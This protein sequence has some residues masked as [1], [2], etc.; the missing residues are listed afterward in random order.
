[1]T[2][3]LSYTKQLESRVAELE[4]ALSK[5]VGQHSSE[6]SSVK[7]ESPASPAEANASPSRR[8]KI[9]DG[10]TDNLDLIK[11]F[12]GL[13]VERDGR[14]SFHGPTSLFQLPSSA[15]ERASPS[16]RRVK[17]LGASRERLINNAWRE[18]AFEQLSAIP[19]PFQYLLDSHWCW[20]QPLFNFVYRPAFTRDMKI[21][22]P[23][24]SDVLLNAILSHS[25]RWCRA[26]PTIGPLLDPFEGGAQFHQRAV[27]GVLDSLSTGYAGIPTVQTLLLLSAQEC[28]QGNRTQ[29]WLYS[30]MAFRL[31]DDL[32][33]SIDSRKY[34]GSAHLTDEDIETRNR[35]FWS[36]YFWDKM[37]SLYF[38]RA[39]IM[40]HSSV[41]PPRRIL[42]DTSEIEIWTPHGIVFPEG[43]HYPPTQ[44]HSTSC[45]MKMCSLTE[46]LNQILIHIYDPVRKSSESEFYSCIQDQAKNLTEWWEEL[47]SYLK[48]VAT[49][50]PPYC[51]PSHIALINCL[52]HTINILLHRPV[53]C[54]KIKPEMYD[55]SHLVQCMSSATTIISIFDLFRRTFGD[56]HVVL[57]LAYSIYTAASI[58]LLEIQALKHAAPMTLENLRFCVFALERIKI[59][60]PVIATA[61]NLIYQELE[62]LHIDL[63]TMPPNQPTAHLSHHQQQ[64]QRHSQSPTRHHHHQHDSHS[65]SVSPIPQHAAARTPITVAD[66][67][68]AAPP[69]HPPY[70]YPPPPGPS[71][72][73]SMVDT[74]HMDAAHHLSEMSMGVNRSTSSYEIAPE[75]FEAFSYTEPITTNMTPYNP[76][77]IGP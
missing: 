1:M 76:A 38:G 23:Y 50:L 69:I 63:Y 64:Q 65:H 11:E 40:Q 52:Y 28:G 58:F 34:S 42:D 13:K 9:V 51:P 41:S 77:W 53:L 20:I 12:E 3:T 5:L 16:V 47:P 21:N 60:N 66:P 73:P 18:R 44:A 35:L 61:L 62:K 25:V 48:L 39:P 31:L 43:T 19:E 6:A 33:I 55:Q 27:S 24:Y 8:I 26:D 68:S 54:S 7:G 10:G 30:G 29:A 22:G 71:P 70:A 14:V 36:C 56:S 67:V 17:D 49:D 75:V 46:I 74:S 45:F 15:T 32:G 4:E 2:P 59:S 37:I 72:G 57:S